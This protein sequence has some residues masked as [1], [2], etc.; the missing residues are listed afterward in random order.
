MERVAEAYGQGSQGSATECHHPSWG[1][2]GKVPGR[3]FPGK[4]E[5]HPMKTESTFGY[6]QYPEAAMPTTTTLC[7][8]SLISSSFMAPALGNQHGG[9]IMKLEYNHL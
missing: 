3:S 4:P 8:D 6:L 2:Q 1:M 9:E 7:I 5:K